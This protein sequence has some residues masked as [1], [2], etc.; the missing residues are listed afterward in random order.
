MKPIA[1]PFQF[2]KQ[3]LPPLCALAGVFAFAAP[4]QA[5]VSQTASYDATLKVPKCTGDVNDCRSGT[6]LNGRGT[7]GPEPNRPNTL[8]GTCADSTGGSYHGDE[9][10]DALQITSVDGTAFGAGKSVTV[11]ATVWAYSSYSSDKLDIY[12]SPSVSNPSW[13]LM[14]TLTPTK[15]GSGVLQ[16]TF[17]LSAG[18]A[19]QAIRGVFRYGGSATPCDTGSY[20]DRD[21]LVFPVAGSSADTTA[22]SVSFA[23]PAN[24]ANL[25]GQVTL[26]ANAS[27]NVGVT[28][29]SFYDGDSFIG[30]TTGA[31]Y[32]ISWNAATA[33]LG[34]HSLKAVAYDAAGNIGTSII[35]VNVQSAGD[36]TPPTVSFGAPANNSTLTSATTLQVSASDNVGVSRVEFYDGTAFLGSDS[37]APYAMAWSGS[38]GTHT[39]KAVAYDAAGNQSSSS[40]SVNVQLPPPPQNAFFDAT[41]AGGVGYAVDS[42]SY[43]ATVIAVDAQ[44]AIFTAAANGVYVYKHDLNGA[45]DLSWNGT[46]LVSSGPGSTCIPPP[47]ST[48]AVLPGGKLL[49]ASSAC[50]SFSSPVIDA[51]VTRLNAD[52]TL[53]TTFG[54]S[55]NIFQHAPSNVDTWST[56]I[57]FYNNMIYLV[58][59]E[60][61]MAFVSRYDAAGNTDFS[62]GTSGIARFTLGSTN[63]VFTDIKILGDGKIALSGVALDQGSYIFAAARLSANGVLDTGFN[64]S[65]YRT[66]RVGTTTTGLT[67]Y[68]KQLAVDASGNFYLAGYAQTTANGTYNL[69]VVKLTNSGQFDTTWNGSGTVVLPM[70]GNDSSGNAILIAPNGNVLLGAKAFQGSSIVPTLVRFTPAGV[71]DASFGSNGIAQQVVSGES[72]AIYDMAFQPNGQLVTTGSASLKSYILRF[73]P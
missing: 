26:Q 54:Q 49:V 32:A 45:K 24:N 41:F 55:G 59:R 43:P 71:L 36:T 33:T 25:T 37:A 61:S 73:N 62:F 67:S 69:A 5:A 68:T 58:G 31:P 22:P 1:H 11:T 66:V 44:G 28:K 6:L 52:G 53:D 18:E 10:L 56:K 4:A 2:I 3:T 14:T 23:A 17:S 40:I 63:A 65:G 47:N 42:G 38:N 70:G 50:R 51:A 19:Q 35:T 16:A 8:Y 48:M 60:G 27:D 39:L 13:R 15:A 21:D 64:T 34:S 46:G 7:L 29:V 9:S 30:G 20:N 72:P 12:Y 57:M